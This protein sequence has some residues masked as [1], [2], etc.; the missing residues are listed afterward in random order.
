MIALRNNWKAVNS[1]CGGGLEPFDQW[2]DLPVWMREAD[3]DWARE[4]GK[5]GSRSG[6]GG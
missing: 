6:D 2:I 3:E 4:Q 1:Y 5:G